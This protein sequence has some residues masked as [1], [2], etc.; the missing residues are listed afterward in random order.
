MNKQL[1]VKIED[2]LALVK[3]DASPLA[4]KVRSKLTGALDILREPPEAAPFVAPAAK[5]ALPTDSK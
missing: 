2:A 1:I 5:P 3:D 4:H